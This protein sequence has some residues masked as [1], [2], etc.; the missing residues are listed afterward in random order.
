[1]VTPE[2]DQGEQQ[3]HLKMLKLINCAANAD[4][5]REQGHGQGRGH[6]PSAT[7]LSRVTTKPNANDLILAAR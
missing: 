5:G 4:R 3:T 1:M 7:F 6:N 2:P